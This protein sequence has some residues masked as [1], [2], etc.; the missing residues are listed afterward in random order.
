MK[1]VWLPGPAFFAAPV[2]FAAL[3]APPSSPIRDKP[4]LSKCCWVDEKDCEVSLFS[5]RQEM[6]NNKALLFQ[7]FDS[8]H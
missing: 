5:L 4:S 6:V 3:G 1:Y 7:R 2:G 8:M